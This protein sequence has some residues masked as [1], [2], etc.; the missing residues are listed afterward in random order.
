MRTR[1]VLLGVLLGVLASLTGCTGQGV[2]GP[3]NVSPPAGPDPT[4]VVREL[5]ETMRAARTV[6]YEGSVTTWPG[7]QNATISGSYDF[8]TRRGEGRVTSSPDQTIEVINDGDVV[9]VKMPGLP[10]WVRADLGQ[11]MVSAPDLYSHLEVIAGM[12]DVQAA[13]TAVVRGVS[14]RHF[15]GTI[16]LRKYLSQTGFKPEELTIVPAGSTVQVDVYLD[17][18]NLLRRLEITA[19]DDGPWGG[20]ATTDYFDYGADVS[21]QVPDP[22]QV[23]ELTPPPAGGQ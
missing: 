6:R 4:Q 15:T 8:T 11:V 9:Y 1:I 3:A 19:P 10:R 21:I 20:T 2:S 13:G 7:A 16:D 14:T 22:S 18:N 23:D 17:S 5:A 12:D